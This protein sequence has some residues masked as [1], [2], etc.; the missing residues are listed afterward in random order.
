[1]LLFKEGNCCCYT[2]LLRSSEMFCVLTSRRGKQESKSGNVT[3][4]LENFEN[5]CS[6]Q[7]LC[8]SY[9]PLIGLYGISF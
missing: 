3:H 1:M 7:L 8:L 2:K 4:T 9:N 5:A 6:L